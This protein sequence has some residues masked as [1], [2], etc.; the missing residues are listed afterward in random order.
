[1]AFGALGP[2]DVTVHNREVE[3]HL[4]PAEIAEVVAAEN[5]ELRR[6]EE[7]YRGGRLPLAF[8]GEVTIIV[9]DGLATGAT[10]RAAVAAARRLGAACAVLAVPVGARESVELLR[11]E[12]DEVV[13]PLI[14]ERFGAVSRWYDTFAQTTDA[15]VTALLR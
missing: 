12:A 3:S 11:G 5:E 7:L 9:D 15:E 6:R 8:D 1:V 13:C 10:A 4:S 14:P 2:A